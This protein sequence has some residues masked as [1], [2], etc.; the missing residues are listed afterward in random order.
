MDGILYLDKRE[1]NKT[2]FTIVCITLTVIAIIINIP[3]VVSV[4]KEEVKKSNF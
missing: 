3:V 1:E 4:I 2:M